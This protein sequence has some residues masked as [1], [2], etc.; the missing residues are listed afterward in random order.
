VKTINLDALGQSGHRVEIAGVM[1][2]VRQIT[3]RVAN[4][5][6]SA[7]EADGVARLR[8]YY[9]AVALLIPSM[10]RLDVDDLSAGQIARIMQIARME[11]DAV[12]EAATD[13][14]AASSAP[15]TV[16]EP[17]TTPAT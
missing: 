12:D 13:P 9:D 16:T 15:T 5:I 17:A 14:N 2:T 4:I 1:H 11:V 6:A 3:A 10:S 7:E 8:L